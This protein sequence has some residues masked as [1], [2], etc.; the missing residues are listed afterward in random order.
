MN[1]PPLRIEPLSACIG[2]CIEG[3]DLSATLE[4]AQ[5]AEKWTEWL[6]RGGGGSGR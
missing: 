2:A 1:S 6:Q 5:V 3:V 4:A